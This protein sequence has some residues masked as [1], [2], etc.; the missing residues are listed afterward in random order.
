MFGGFHIQ[1]NS[2][3][4]FPANSYYAWM[5]PCNKSDNLHLNVKT[6]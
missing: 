6:Q 4:E 3:G 5:I 2:Y 1:Y